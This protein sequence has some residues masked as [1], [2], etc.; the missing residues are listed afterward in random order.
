[1]ALQL[2]G[3]KI[4][5][6]LRCPPGG[7]P[8]IATVSFSPD[9]CGWEFVE[10]ALP[11]DPTSQRRCSSCMSIGSN[12]FLSSTLF[13]L[14]EYLA[15]RTDP[16]Q[17][18]PAEAIPS[19][20]LVTMPE[21][22]E[23]RY[24]RQTVTHGLEL[25]ILR[26]GLDPRTWAVLMP[27]SSIRSLDTSHR[28]SSRVLP[29]FAGPPIVWTALPVLDQARREQIL[30]AADAAVAAGSLVALPLFGAGGERGGPG[31]QL[32][33][34]LTVALSLPTLASR[35]VRWAL[36]SK[37]RFGGMVVFMFMI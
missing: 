28:A 1:M 21:I 27:D 15:W 4:E 37:L 32:R 24:Y 36:R 23:K 13:I 19:S 34:F 14:V 26:R 35:W 33:R 2:L 5:R 17:L 30:Q 31:V 20:A 3:F 29:N 18:G 8:A 6:L 25:A 16:G 7:V 9:A 12:C 22:W 10:A 11:R